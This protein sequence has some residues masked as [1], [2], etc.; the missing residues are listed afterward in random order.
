MRDLA[1][2]NLVRYDGGTVSA[3]FS[4]PDFRY[5]EQSGSQ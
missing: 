2:A 5:P 3:T 4:F 1:V